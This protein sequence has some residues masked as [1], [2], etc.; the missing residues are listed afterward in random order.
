MFYATQQCV[1]LPGPE[2]FILGFFAYQYHCQHKILTDKIKSYD[3]NLKMHQE[4]I[5]EVI[6]HHNK[7][8]NICD[9][10]INV[11]DSLP[12]GAPLDTLHVSSNYGSRKHPITKHRKHWICQLIQQLTDKTN[13]VK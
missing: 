11:M 12:L 6:D 4:K 8:Y 9:S 10:L 7:M 5:D 2:V 1:C 3:V 13:T